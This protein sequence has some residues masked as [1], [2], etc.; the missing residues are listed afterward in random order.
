MSTTFDS[1]KPVLTTVQ[2]LKVDYDATDDILRCQ[3]YDTE[4]RMIEVGYAFS[5]TGETEETASV[6]IVI[7]KNE[8]TRINPNFDQ[9][10]L[11]ATLLGKLSIA[12]SV[13]D[14]I[15]FVDAAKRFENSYELFVA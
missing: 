1:A 15:P 13:D 7:I 9:W 4:H 2:L 12:T 11:A 14:C 8:I 5:V 6:S 10:L 3:L